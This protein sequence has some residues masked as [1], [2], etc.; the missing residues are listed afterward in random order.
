[1]H[2]YGCRAVISFVVD[3]ARFVFDAEAGV[4]RKGQSGV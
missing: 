3:S 1:M 2:I 4:D